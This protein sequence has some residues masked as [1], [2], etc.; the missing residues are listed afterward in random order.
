MTQPSTTRTDY[1]RIFTFVIALAI[2]LTVNDAR[3]TTLLPP[4][5]STTTWTIASD[6]KTIL[7]ST[8][9]GAPGPFIVKGVDYSPRP[10]ND[11]ALTTPGSD[12]FWGD[13][14]HLTYGPIW[15]RDLWGTTY[16]D[17][18]TGNNLP[19][20]LVRQLG[21]NS[22]RTYAWW[23]WVPMVPAD[24]SKWNK[25]DWSVS[26]RVRF[27]ATAAPAGFAAYPAHD[28]GDQFL[29]LCWNHGV[30]PIYV[31]IG[32]SLDPW[33][34]FASVSP[35]PVLIHD[36]RMYIERT[37][38]WLAQRYGYHPAVLGFAIGNET[39]LPFEAGTDRYI[40]Y[41]NYLNR[42]GAITKRYAPGKLTMTAFADY[43]SGE[44]P[45][46]LTPL[47]TFKDASNTHPGGQTEPEC[48]DASGSNPGPDCTSADRRQ[49]Y[50]GDIYALDVWGFNAYR[51]PETEEVANFKHWIVDGYYT[52]G[53]ELRGEPPNPVPKPMLL[54]EW[55]A[56]ASVR[57][58]QGQPPP[59][60]NSQW[61]SASPAA[62][63][64]FH[65]AA[66]ISHG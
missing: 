26:P 18:Q 24:Y 40:D 56:P 21:A 61:V 15:T 23:K 54:T 10:I 62:T 16:N 3:S 60:P 53:L 1:L 31:V 37:T 6:H 51:R 57:T 5:L 64:E 58:R 14:A 36:E 47:V 41:W 28:G 50:P 2:A 9:G 45:M 35:D 43:P 27:G 22:I 19:D 49:A 8:N 66:R 29:D 39:N 65:D 38:K 11:A 25:L 63:G 30:N 4:D 48:V 52:S 42:L 44:T 46:L 59:P 17:Y 32:I 13:P 55:G 7:L 33:N 34:A 20:G 12:Y